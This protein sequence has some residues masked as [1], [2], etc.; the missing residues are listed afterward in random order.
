VTAVAS[1]SY[2]FARRLPALLHTM[3]AANLFLLALAILAAAFFGKRL[4]ARLGS[5]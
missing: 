2:V 3:R 5:D 1:V 4:L